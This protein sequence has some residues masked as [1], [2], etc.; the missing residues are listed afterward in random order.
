[1][2]LQK[3]SFHFQGKVLIEKATLQPPYRHENVF[4]DEGCF[5]YMK[6]VNGKLMSAID[7]FQFDAAP[8]E[9]LLLKCGNYFVDFVATA[10]NQTVEVI[11]VHLYS[12]VLKKIF[13]NEPLTLLQKQ[14][15]DAQAK[16][17][18][19]D[20]VI[21]KFIESLEFYFENPA[22]INDH[23]LELKVKELVLLLIQTK[24]AHSVFELI[25]SFYST[26]TATLKEIVNLHLYSNLTVEELA[27]LASMSVATF[28]RAFKKEFNSSPIHYINTKKLKQAKELLSLPHLTIS[29]IAYQVGFNDPLYFSRF[30]KQKEGV[31]PSDFRSSFTQ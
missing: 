1:M 12:D 14:A 13:I 17:I 28:K 3:Q 25:N 7:N 2:I 26:R 5:L 20:V 27:K 29:D 19:D 4:Q 11:A 9:A 24:N 23:L 18:A 16:R 8:T 15:T 6:G 31:S 21:A 22:L 30:F 10:Q